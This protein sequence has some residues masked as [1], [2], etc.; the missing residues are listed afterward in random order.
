MAHQY[1]QNK[2]I[3]CL[4]T[5]Q[6]TDICFETVD[7]TVDMTPD[8]VKLAYERRF[9]ATVDENDV[10]CWSRQPIRN[11][12]EGD[13]DFDL[14]P[15]T[16]IP[17]AWNERRDGWEVKSRLRLCRFCHHRLPASFG[18]HPNIT[19]GLC[20][21]SA[22]GKTV[23]MLSL[24]HDLRR[25]P[26][27]SVTPDPV[28]Y[29]EMDTDYES[30]YNAM[31]TNAGGYV[32]PSAT[33]PLDLLSP[34]VLDC[35]YSRGGRTREFSITVFDMAGEG[36]KS[37]S[38]MAKQ[39]V[40]LENV[41]GVIY[42]KNPD[43][44][45][46]MKMEEDA[47]IEHAY[48]PAL[49]DAITMR[50]E[51]AERARIAITITKF[52]K[53]LSLYGGL[54]EMEKLSDMLADNPLTLHGRGF[55]VNRAMILNQQLYKFYQMENTRDQRIITFYDSQR[56]AAARQQKPEARRGL[57]GRLFGGKSEP[58]E[59]V[60]AR[61]SVMLFAASPLGRDAQ[62]VNDDCN[63]MAVAP[64]GMMN[65]DPLLWLLYC[66]DLYPARAMD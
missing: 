58:E 37:T 48:L 9:D 59:R 30:L 55:D 57:F 66:C 42:L 63:Q 29:S 5:L 24:I 39:A 43:Y 14:D 2:C 15:D 17:V 8:P 65:V 34:L 21:N 33:N 20:G 35:Q 7:D 26:N 23:Y 38:Y 6:R 19:I 1:D 31:Y 56:Q 46:G 50:P 36:V 40:Y 44:Y 64:S 18:K 41:A 45:P 53:V 28:F 25:V 16:G 11:Y 4:K 10:R 52:D 49:I 60:S 13:P 54:P 62:F 51:G 22:A 32:L 61:Q 47:L 27:M 12:V 3:F